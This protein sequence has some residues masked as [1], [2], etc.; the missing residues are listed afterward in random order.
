MARDYKKIFNV[1]KQNFIGAI[2]GA[3]AAYY[4]SI[5]YV[6]NI[7]YTY[8]LIFLGMSYLGATIQSKL[9]K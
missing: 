6:T 1:I 3:V 2:A 9:K 8:F 7:P 5:N 4:I